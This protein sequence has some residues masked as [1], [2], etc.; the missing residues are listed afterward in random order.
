M[1]AT[2][3]ELVVRLTPDPSA[4]LE[5]L[6]TAAGA[7]I[8]AADTLRAAYPVLEPPFDRTTT[9][10][11]YP[12]DTTATGFRVGD[13]VRS[14]VDVTGDG[15][16]QLGTVTGVVHESPAGYEVAFDADTT[17]GSWELDGSDLEP[18]PVLDEQPATVGPVPLVTAVNEALADNVADVN[19]ADTA[20]SVVDV[21]RD[22][23]AQYPEATPIVDVYRDLFGGAQ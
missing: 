22:R 10:P 18:A 3:R 17:P 23:L 5:F 1:N 21:F 8:T 12:W 4:L 16:G 14:V 20:Q 6:D 15:A 7:L 19:A 9:D 2:E 13:R 11:D